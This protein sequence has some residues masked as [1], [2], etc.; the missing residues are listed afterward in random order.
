[1]TQTTTGKGVL[2]GKHVLLMVIAFFGVMIVANVA[3][4]SAALRSFPGVTDEHAYQRGLEYN[5]KLSARASQASLGW[6]AEVTE[7]TRDE[8]TGVIAL[9]MTDASSQPISGLE[10]TAGLRR[11]ADDAQDQS[12]VFAYRSDGYYETRVAAFAPGVWDLTAQAQNAG[13]DVFDIEARII[14]P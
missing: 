14:A 2:T 3:F 9:R 4:I 13:G 1:M 5:E 11:P 6:A 10:I 12:L 7:V 8:E